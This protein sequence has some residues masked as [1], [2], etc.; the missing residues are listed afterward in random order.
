MTRNAS[1]RRRRRLT[2]LLSHAATSGGNKNAAL[3]TSAEIDA[4]AYRS[5]EASFD[6]QAGGFTPRQ[7]SRCR[8]TWSSFST[9]TVERAMPRALEMAALTFRKHGGR[10]IV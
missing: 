7:N 6:T 4:L 3:P 5:L 8:S 10:R 9:I 2:D 1:L